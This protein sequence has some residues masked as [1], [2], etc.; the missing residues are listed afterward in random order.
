MSW[1]VKE[2]TERDMRAA[3]PLTLDAVSALT[4]E[5]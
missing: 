5:T 4:S 2:P 3:T 1:L